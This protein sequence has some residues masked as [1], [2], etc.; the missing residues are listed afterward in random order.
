MI[1]ANCR[2]TAMGIL[3]HTD[4]ERALELACSLDIPFWPQLPRVSYWEDMYVQVSEN[5]PGIL[6]DEANRRI[7]FDTGRFYQELETF[8]ERMEDPDL[9]RLSP[10]YSVV[11]HAFLERDLSAFPAIRGQVEG[12][13][14]AFG[15]PKWNNGVG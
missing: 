2:T 9:Y 12:P 7:D 6:I 11:Y 1:P 14:H 8:V 15:P 4:V 13:V 5:F 3:P 10:R